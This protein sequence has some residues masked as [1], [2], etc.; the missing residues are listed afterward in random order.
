[1]RRNLVLAYR[2]KRAG[3]HWSLR[4]ILEARRH[5]IP[6]SLAFAV[7]EQETG[8]R[9]VFGHDR[10][11]KPNPIQGG[12][13]TR[14]KYRRYCTYLTHG[15][16][17]QGVGPC[18]LTSRHLQVAAD[19]LGGCWK[20]KHNI[21]VGMAFLGALLRKQGSVR[22]ALVA[23]N[24]AA[25]YADRVLARQARWHRILTKGDRS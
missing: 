20:P 12:A 16:D 9:N 2:A 7:V 8:F 1:M 18:Q 14:D 25:I 11:K 10:G 23:Y 4:I 24:G 15:Y 17:L 13:V 5:R 6:I 21:E 22:R 19:N 3:A